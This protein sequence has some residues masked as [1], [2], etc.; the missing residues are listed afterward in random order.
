MTLQLIQKGEYSITPA[1]C[2]VS[3]VPA[4]PRAFFKRHIKILNI[5]VLAMHT[6]SH[7]EAEHIS[8]SIIMKN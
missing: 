4:P 7:K 8:L 6:L 5:V 3:S 1:H 2:G